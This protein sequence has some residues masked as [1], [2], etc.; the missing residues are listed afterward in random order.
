MVAR[1]TPSYWDTFLAWSRLKP[2]LCGIRLARLGTLSLHV[3]RL[4][5]KMIE[6]R[7]EIAHEEQE[8]IKA[9]LRK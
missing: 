1:C 3:A 2:T 5:R 7:D 9:L 4:L 6:D 8:E